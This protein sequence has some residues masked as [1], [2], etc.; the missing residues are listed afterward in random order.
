MFIALVPAFI[1]GGIIYK[2]QQA[3]SNP[4]ASNFAIY[5]GIIIFFLAILICSV[6]IGVLLQALNSIFIFFCLDLRFKN[7]GLNTYNIPEE[8]S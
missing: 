2:I 3:Q 1:G 6:I 5:G 4:L 7:M 8:I